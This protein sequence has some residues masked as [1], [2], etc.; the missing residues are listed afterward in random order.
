MMVHV[1][2][3]Q[4]RREWKRAGMTG[5][6]SEKKWKHGHE[7]FERLSVC[8]KCYTHVNIQ[9]SPSHPNTCTLV[10][11]LRIW[12]RWRCLSTRH[13]F[14]DQLSVLVLLFPYAHTHSVSL[15]DDGFSL[16]CIRK[17]FA[18]YNVH[19]YNICIFSLCSRCCWTTTYAVAFHSLFFLPTSRPPP[20]L[21]SR[22]Y[23]F[24]YM[25][26]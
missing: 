25:T 4:K 10:S 2:W 21:S 14:L 17:W 24:P 8:K 11:T 18:I 26:H 15:N 3:C 19:I 5:V 9:S 1:L 16:M 22:V 6:R 20:S 23:L 7:V 13:A 12:F